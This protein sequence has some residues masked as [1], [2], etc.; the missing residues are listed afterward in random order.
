MGEKGREKKD[1]RKRMGENASL[2][3]GREIG[4]GKE[5]VAKGV[6]GKM[7]A[8]VTTQRCVARPAKEEKD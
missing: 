5:G 6:D 3:A 1:G 7:P 2:K 8:Y 4:A